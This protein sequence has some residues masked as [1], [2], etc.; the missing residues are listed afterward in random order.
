M[1]ITLLQDVQFVDDTHAVHLVGQETH[2]IWEESAKVPVGQLEPN[3]H[4]PLY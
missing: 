4:D 3:M 1:Y 2:F